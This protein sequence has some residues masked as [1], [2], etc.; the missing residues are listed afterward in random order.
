MSTSCIGRLRVAGAART[1][2]LEN[3]DVPGLQSWLR[4]PLLGVCPRPGGLSP[5]GAA[6]ARLSS[7]VAVG[8][9]KEVTPR[10]GDSGGFVDLV[11]GRHLL[12]HRGGVTPLGLFV[13]NGNFNSCSRRLLPLYLLFFFIFNLFFSAELLAHTVTEKLSRGF[14]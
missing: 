5:W 12:A 7:P 11:L 9:N 4:V 1:A 8:T 2:S 3:T 6:G 13:H 14:M 10:W